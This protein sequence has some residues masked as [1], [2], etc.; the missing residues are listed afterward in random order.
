MEL[1][2]F[3]YPPPNQQIP[4]SV[5]GSTGVIQFQ[6]KPSVPTCRVGSAELAF[7]IG[8]SRGNMAFRNG[9]PADSVHCAV[10]QRKRFAS[11]RAPH[12]NGVTAPLCS[13]LSG[14][15]PQTRCT[16]W[17]VPVITWRF[18]TVWRQMAGTTLQQQRERFASRRAAG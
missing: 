5:S 17:V 15:F 11:R 13:Y 16:W 18:G 8:C 9:N 6:I 7:L 3:P 12:M 10:L 14:L 1:L 2:T 4:W